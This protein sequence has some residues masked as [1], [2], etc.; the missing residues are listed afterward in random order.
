MGLSGDPPKAL[1]DTP[2]YNVPVLEDLTAALGVKSA[3]FAGVSSGGSIAFYLAAK[4]PEL[5]ERLVLSNT[6]AD[7]VESKGMKQSRALAAAGP[8]KSNKYAPVSFWRAFFDFF[9]GEPERVTDAKVAEYYDMNRRVPAPSKMA[10][11]EAMADRAGTQRQLASISAPVLLVWGGRDPLL[12]PPTADT[13]AGYLKGTQ[14]SKLML[15]DVGHYPPLEAPERFAQIV[16]TYIAAVT[17]VKPRAP[18]P[19]DR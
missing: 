11:V 18:A 3:T 2:L 8:T 9:T 12:T 10:V 6:P 4:R 19:A 16:E 17:P 14:V 1:L 13:L 5:V 7:P 15:P